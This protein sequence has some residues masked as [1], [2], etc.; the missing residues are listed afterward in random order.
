[1]VGVLLCLGSAAA[2]STHATDAYRSFDALEAAAGE[3]ITV[4]VVFSNLEPADLRGFFFT[5]HIPVGLSVTTEAVMIGGVRVGYVYETGAVGDVYAGSVPHRW[6][7]ET[8]GD[9]TQDNPVAPSA[10]VTIIYRLTSSDEGAFQLGAFNWAG[11][12]RDALGAAFGHSEGADDVALV[13]AAGDGGGGGQ[14]GSGGGGGG[15]F[16]ISALY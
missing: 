12:Y 14:S 11:Y 10:T 15:C 3:A 7:L 1:M 2:F 5:E 6:V 9:F 8:P 13:F 4:T 16:I